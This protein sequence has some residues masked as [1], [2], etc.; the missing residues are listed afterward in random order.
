MLK[1][2][3]TVLLIL[4]TALTVFAEPPEVVLPPVN[5]E[6]METINNPDVE[7]VIQPPSVPHKKT[8]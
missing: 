1:N 8:V 7:T 4:F 5:T 3:L 6:V 2:N